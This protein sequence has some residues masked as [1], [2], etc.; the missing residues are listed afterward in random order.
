[1]QAT[2]TDKPAIAGGK[3]AKTKPY[4]K[5]ARYGDEEMNELK[6]AVAQGTL[7]YASGKKVK[8]LEKAFAEKHGAKFGIASSSGTAAIHAATMAAGIS[9][10]DEVIVP[11]ITDMGTIL[12]VMWQGAVPIFCDLDPHTYNM[13]PQAIEAVLSERTRAIIA[14]HLAGNPCELRAI[15]QI[16]DKRKIILIED[17]AQ[18]HGT[19][20]DGKP[21]GSFGH[22]GCYSFNEYKH[23][24]TGDGGMITTSDAELAAKLRLATDKAYDRSPGVA[25]R[26]PKFMA[27]N[28]RMTEL[29]GAVALAQL[30]KLD[31]IVN[32]RNS[33]GTRLTDRL[34]QFQ[35]V[36]LN[37]PAV[38]PGGTHTYWFCMMRVDKEKL[39]ASADEFTAA[40]KAEG[41]PVSAHYITRPIY[42]YPLFVNHSAFER[43]DHPYK[44]VN[45]TQV[46]CPNAE[47]ILDTCVIMPVNE[48]YSDDDLEETAKAFEKVVGHF[49]A[50]R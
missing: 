45:Y 11:P 17:C 20:Y 42:K 1:M 4:A 30:K 15:Q 32:R 41:L 39:G 50:K 47:N 28:Y 44:R 38:T 35:S 31:S 2:T 46:K 19:K 23:I 25:I 3:P 12:P 33:W 18:S 29:Q 16:A 37:M 27:N 22:I 43:G 9:P 14:V 13:T 26:D 36:G 7:F 6:E 5:E 40:L 8:A 48:A 34:K 10:G 21:V 24:S 49:Q